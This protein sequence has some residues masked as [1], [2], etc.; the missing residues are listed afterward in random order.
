MTV[1]VEPRVQVCPLTVAAAFTSAPFGM[2]VR[3]VPTP[4]AGVPSAGAV[5]VGEVRVLLVK[6]WMPV[7]VTSVEGLRLNCANVRGVVPTVTTSEVRTHWV[8]AFAVPLITGIAPVLF[9]SDGES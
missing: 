7:K 3:L 5:I 4:E 6:V 2:P 8:L 1:Q 9:I